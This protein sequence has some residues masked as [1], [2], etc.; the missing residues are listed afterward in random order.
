MDNERLT[1]EMIDCLRP[2]E[3]D[4]SVEAKL[5]RHALRQVDWQ[6]KRIAELEAEIAENDETFELR[7]ERT[8]EADREWQ[9]ATG[10]HG[11]FPDLGELIEWLRGDRDQLRALL[12]WAYRWVPAVSDAAAES[13]DEVEAG[14]N[15]IDDELSTALSATG[16]PEHPDTA[17]LRTAIIGLQAI[18]AGAMNVSPSVHARACLAAIDAPP[19]VDEK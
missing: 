1:P 19:E 11:V 5:M 17:R 2:N 13:R 3:S 9:Q 16:E 7:R 8:V 14:R 18:E 6:A 4:G 10:R 12:V 15:M